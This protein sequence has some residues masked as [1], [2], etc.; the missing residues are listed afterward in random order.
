LRQKRFA[1]E[2]IRIQQ[3]SQALVDRKSLGFVRVA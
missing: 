2:D 1:A 3:Q